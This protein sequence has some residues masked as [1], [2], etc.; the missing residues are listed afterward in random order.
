MLFLYN[1]RQRS[2][3]KMLL[4]C[5]IPIKLRLWKHEKFVIW[6]NNDN[7][8]WYI[9][10]WKKL[11]GTLFKRRQNRMANCPNLAS[12]CKSTAGLRHVVLPFLKKSK[13]KHSE[14]MY[15]PLN[16]KCDAKISTSGVSIWISNF[17]RTQR[18]GLAMHFCWRKVELT[19]Q[20]MG[21]SSQW[22]NYITSNQCTLLYF[23]ISVEP[24]IDYH[25]TWKPASDMWI[26]SVSM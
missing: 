16:K 12:Q 18:Q 10:A 3:K 11:E 6:C 5:F 26:P 24:K 20:L 21:P 14:L 4:L 25:I 8:V 17:N 15:G 19:F 9:L 22:S 2:L 7:A 23:Q 1:C 13:V